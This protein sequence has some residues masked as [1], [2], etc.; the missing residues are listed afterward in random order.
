MEFYVKQVEIESLAN[1][2]NS[3]ERNFKSLKDECIN[4]INN[5]NSLDTFDG[6]AA[7]SMKDYMAEVH[8][9][10][11]LMLHILLAQLKTDF[12]SVYQVRYN[13]GGGIYEGPADNYG[14]YPVS[15]L[16]MASIFI[17]ALLQEKVTPAEIHLKRA[18]SH[19]PPGCSVEKPPDVSPLV[20]V[21]QDHRNKIDR[22]KRN[23]LLAEECGRSAF[24][25]QSSNFQNAMNA[26]QNAIAACLDAEISPVGY[27]SESFSEIA[28]K[29]GLTSSYLAS[30]NDIFAKQK[31]VY[32][33]FAECIQHS[34]ARVEDAFEEAAQKK[35]TEAIIGTAAAVTGAALGA[36]AM[37]ATCGAATPVVAAVAGVVGTFGFVSDAVDVGL[38]L[39]QCA[40]IGTGNYRADRDP[41]TNEGTEVLDDTKNLLD[42]GKYVDNG[43][44]HIGMAGGQTVGHWAI[45][46]TFDFLESQAPNAEEKL[47]WKIGGNAY[48]FVWDTAWDAE[49]K[50]L[51]AANLAPGNLVVGVVRSVG[52]AVEAV[53]DYH[54][55]EC[56]K[57]MESLD[58]EMKRL[59]SLDNYNKDC[60]SF[61][62]IDLLW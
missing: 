34:R 49:I 18:A 56:D 58:A 53:A 45:G 31:I 43:G 47:G 44:E 50:T 55:D 9:H 27:V 36:A 51:D 2:I 40:E 46:H 17:Q 12:I 59:D 42:F 19:I 60:R 32:N 52:K 23:V 33:S 21:L 57:Q 16:K 38:H 41:Y 30:Y 6:D 62:S 5:F 3:L 35:Q 22:L 11:L 13:E 8:G 39:K 14:E 29:A 1:E 61:Q 26:L 54:M 48:S 37:V 25:S 4:A 15:G 24:I 28:T 10:L 7:Q 20:S